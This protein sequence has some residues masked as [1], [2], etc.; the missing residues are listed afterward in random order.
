MNLIT[1]QKARQL[2]EQAATQA[3]ILESIHNAIKDA[4]WRGETE[5]TIDSRGTFVVEDFVSKW[6]IPAGYRV[7]H[8]SGEFTFTLS[9]A[10]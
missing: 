4:A 1:A 6:L 7:R 9:W 5:V 10:E 3:A 8:N 2:V